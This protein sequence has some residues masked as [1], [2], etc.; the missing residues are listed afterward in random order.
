[1]PELK[2]VLPNACLRRGFGRQADFLIEGYVDPRE[3]LRDEGS[4]GD[5]AGPR[6]VRNA[7]CELRMAKSPSAA[8]S[9]ST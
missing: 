7:R 1:L 3:L 4:F 9:A 2:I 8:N 6:K 5:H